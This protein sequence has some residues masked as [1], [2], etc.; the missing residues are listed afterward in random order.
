[1]AVVRTSKG[2]SEDVKW[3]LWQSQCFFSDVCIN[4]KK[5]HPLVRGRA[6]HTVYLF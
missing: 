1:M 2:C 4:K 5:A 3:A 6:F